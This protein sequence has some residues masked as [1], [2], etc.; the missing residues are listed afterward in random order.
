[1]FGL[2]IL[3]G[4]NINKFIFTNIKKYDIKKLKFYFNH[5]GIGDWAQSPYNYNKY[6]K[7]IY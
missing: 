3:Q 5:M 6:K 2:N 1:M 4:Y 7:N